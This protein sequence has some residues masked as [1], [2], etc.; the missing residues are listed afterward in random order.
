MLNF[1][2]I[3]T[4]QEIAELKT[5]VPKLAEAIQNAANQQI[6]WNEKLQAE[7]FARMVQDPH[8]RSVF[9]A[10]TDQVFRLSKDSAILQKFTH[11]LNQH[12][13]PSFFGSFDQVM[14]KALKFF[15]PL[16][17]SFLSPPIVWSIL[18]V[19]RHKTRNV[20]LPGELL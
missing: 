12:G 14:L 19:M 17:P 10:L 13:V 3:L 7:E 9:M 6:R 16:V 18:A 20:I 15:G 11:I 2:S 1:L 5:C 4:T 8:S